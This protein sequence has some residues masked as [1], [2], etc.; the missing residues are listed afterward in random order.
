MMRAFLS[1]SATTRRWAALAVV[2]RI[3]SGVMA[4]AVAAAV[5][6]FLGVLWA[7]DGD[8]M[9][10]PPPIPGFEDEVEAN[11]LER[12]GVP[13]SVDTRDERSGVLKGDGSR[14][15]EFDDGGSDDVK[16]ILRIWFSSTSISPLFFSAILVIFM[17]VFMT[18]STVGTARPPGRPLALS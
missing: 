11:R 17:M 8:P 2:R 1:L 9:R 4:A 12:L 5:G 6:R 15:G 10:L 3:A 14:L 13:A 18:A 16:R 7:L